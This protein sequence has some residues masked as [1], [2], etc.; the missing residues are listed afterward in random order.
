[1][2]R[3]K[4]TRSGHGLCFRVLT[5][6]LILTGAVAARSDAAGVT[7]VKDGK[8]NAVVV[9]PEAPSP[10]ETLAATELTAHV[11]K[12]SGATLATAENGTVPAGLVP[13][14]IGL[15]LCPDAEASIRAVGNDPAAY[16]LAVREDGIHLAGLSPEGT[17]F[18]AYELL[19]QLGVR[20][21]IPGDLGTVVPSAKTL[22]LP[23]Q[24]TVQVP[25][26]GGR[27]LQGVADRTWMRRMRLGGLNAGSHGMKLRRR[28][29]GPELYCQEN[30]KPTHQLEVSHPEVL[31]LVT[32]E[33]LDFFRKHPDAKYFNLSPED[34]PGF[35][36][37]PWDAD[38][39][40]PLHGKISVTDRYVTFFNL[41]LEAVHKEFPNAG[42]AFYCYGQLMRPPIRERP[43]P[44][45]LP[46]LAPIDLCRY[47]DIDNPLCPERRY[48]KEIVD[49]WQKLGCDL[50]YRGFFFNLAD[51]GFP[52]PMTRQIGSELGFFHVSHFNGCRIQ[53]MPLWGHQGPSLYLAC[54]LMWNAGAD[55]QAI[56][57]DYYR[58][59]YGPAAE[60]MEAFFNGLEDAFATADYHTGNV[61]DMPHIL[62]PELM[63]R[64][65]GR[66]KDAEKRA[67]PD[68]LPARRIHLTRLAQEFG[69][70]NLAMI[71]AWNACEFMKAKAGHDRAVALRDEGEALYPG[72]YDK[73]ASGYL[74]RF[75]GAAIQATSEG[76]DNGNKIVARLPDEWLFLLDPLNGGES[77]GFHVPTMGTRNWMPIKTYSQS[78]SNQGLR[79]YKGEAWYR[80][81][82]NV[83]RAFKGETIHLWLGGVDDQADA[84]INGRKLER[85]SRGAAPCGRPWEFDAT[86]TLDFDASNTIVVKVT[87]RALNELGTGGLTGPAMLWTKPGAAK[88]SGELFKGIESGHQ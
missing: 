27:S 84:W 83:S 57:A 55:P 80:T 20:W 68:S 70:A 53:C 69:K 2:Q 34:G 8:A 1:M 50:F 58:A 81:T 63:R 45:L 5:A 24:E 40:D 77:L 36:S 54:K 25:S 28:K 88:P 37:S 26:F 17:L 65:D 4:P 29:T 46:V 39:M 61:F 12:I 16:L 19:E 74:R 22:A 71:E 59:C 32:E 60:P 6:T 48:L 15:A 38:D 62:T 23:L 42:I 64:L 87:N 73:N 31:R 13:I 49:G 10:D 21:C 79:Y 85:L 56:L 35:G 7:V 30:G 51:Q 44:N 14:R 43:H 9:L 72:L 18:A 78:W 76:L 67:P 3:S 47:H 41:V 33:A 66:L 75:W 52:F 82:L 86:G 11:G